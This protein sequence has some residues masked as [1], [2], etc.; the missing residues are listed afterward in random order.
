MKPLETDAQGRVRL[1]LTRGNHL[2]VPMLDHLDE[3]SED[4]H[5][6]YL[7]SGDGNVVGGRAHVANGIRAPSP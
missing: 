1:N 6:F 2:I 3:A 4:D 5:D 7:A